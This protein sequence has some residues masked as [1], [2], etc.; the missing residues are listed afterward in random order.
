MCS[1]DM[2]SVDD[3]PRLV[4]VRDDIYIHKKSKA[5][6]RIIQTPIGRLMVRAGPYLNE[7][8]QLVQLGTNVRTTR[9]TH[10][11]RTQTHDE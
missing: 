9:T 5:L 2:S 10:D 7:L 4:H 3:L 1:V 6:V 11:T 8:V